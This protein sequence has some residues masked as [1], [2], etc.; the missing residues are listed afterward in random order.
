MLKF[1]LLGALLISTAAFSSGCKKKQRPLKAGE[2]S[3]KEKTELRTKA[4]NHYE[5]IA[6]DYPEYANAEDAK[7]RAHA[8]KAEQKK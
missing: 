4:I 7:K 6:M 1:A 3:M 8:L 5:R 2:L